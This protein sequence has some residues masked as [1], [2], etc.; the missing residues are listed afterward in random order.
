MKGYEI[1]VNQLPEVQKHYPK[2]LQVTLHD[3]IILRGLLSVIDREGK[4]WED[5]EVE[6]HCTDNFPNSFPRLYEIGG[7]IPRI[8]DWHVYEDTGSCCVKILPEELLRC[9]NGITI[10]EYIKEEVLPYLFNQTHRRV[11]GYYIAGEYMHGA[12][13]LLQYYSNELKTGNDYKFTLELIKYIATH[14]KPI[15]TSMCFCGKK[16]KFRH[17][18]KI[19]FEKLKAIGYDSLM[20]HYLW[21]SRVT[22]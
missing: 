1:F 21:I 2:L 12:W 18:H 13:G 8:G 4:H 20:N 11:E 14:A 16:L 3:E 9:R 17:C 22:G 7:K 6:I 15:R 19:A 10:L 5:Y